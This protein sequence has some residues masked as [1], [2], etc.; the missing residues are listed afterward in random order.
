MPGL[1]LSAQER[2]NKLNG[3]TGSLGNNPRANTQ[4]PW[5]SDYAPAYPLNDLA[6]FCFRLMASRTLEVKC[7]K[8]S[9]PKNPRMIIFNCLEYLRIVRLASLLRLERL[10]VLV[11]NLNIAHYYYQASGGQAR[12]R[13]AIREFDQTTSKAAKAYYLLETVVSS[14]SD[15]RLCVDG[16]G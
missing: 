11:C 16:H 6:P 5:I 7:D 14:G 2:T 3:R 1:E 15:Q 4:A 9:F 10:V 12:L 13:F 8:T